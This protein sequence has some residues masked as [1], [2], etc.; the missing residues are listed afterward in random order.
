MNSVRMQ[1]RA[2]STGRLKYTSAD[3]YRTSQLVMLHTATCNDIHQTPYY[4]AQ[5]LP[6]QQN[7]PMSNLKN[8]VKH[9]ADKCAGLCPFVVHRYNT[10]SFHCFHHLK[11]YR[12]CICTGFHGDQFTLPSLYD[13][14]AKR[15]YVAE[16]MQHLHPNATQTVVFEPYTNE[17]NFVCRILFW[18]EKRKKQTVQPLFDAQAYKKALD[19]EINWSTNVWQDWF[20]SIDGIILKNEARMSA[21]FKT[22]I[23]VISNPVQIQGN[24]DMT[25]GFKRHAQNIELFFLVKN[26]TP[27][28]VFG[29][30]YTYHADTAATT[31]RFRSLGKINPNQAMPYH[32]QY[33]ERYSRPSAAGNAGEGNDER[34]KTLIKRSH[35]SVYL[36]KSLVSLGF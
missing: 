25:F 8:L 4:A 7:N 12:F 3:V 18:V 30:F 24:L 32:C 21:D 9:V 28:V 11:R 35:V 26:K 31:R 19:A 14:K 22:E 33:S 10:L 36:G 34:T 20:E 1:L 27:A 23:Y 16:P 15:Y 17:F 6:P 2:L 29:C 5:S 13:R